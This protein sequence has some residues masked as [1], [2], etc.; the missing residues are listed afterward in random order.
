MVDKA[1]I[2][3]PVL[4][5]FATAA[6]AVALAFAPPVMTDVAIN[7]P[8]AIKASSAITAPAPSAAPLAAILVP[9]GCVPVRGGVTPDTGKAGVA[10]EAGGS[11]PGVAFKAIVLDFSARCASSSWIVRAAA[12][13][14]CK[15]AESPLGPNAA[16]RARAISVPVAKRSA[17]FF[18][19][20][21]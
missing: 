15:G 18:A 16:D 6:A 14:K 10:P 1:A 4:V 13:C 11:T 21:R 19:I 2:A 17:G 8:N 5:P 12:A 3:T 20:A 7:A 9:V